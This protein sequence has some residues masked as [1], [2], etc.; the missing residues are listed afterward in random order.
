[1]NEITCTICYEDYP[2]SDFIRSSIECQHSFCNN[3]IFNYCKQQIIQANININ[4]PQKK[5]KIPINY[6]TIKYII[7]QDKTIDEKYE[8]FL[9]TETLKSNENV[10]WCPYE[11]CNKYYFI[12]PN[13]NN[14]MSISDKLNCP[15]CKCAICP[16]CYS[17]IHSG[18]SCDT[19]AKYKNKPKTLQTW[20]RQKGNSV[21]NCPNCDCYIEKN[22]GCKHLFCKA[23]NTHFCWICELAVHPNNL[24]EHF[25][26]SDRCSPP[27]KNIFN[28]IRKK[29]DSYVHKKIHI[30]NVTTY[31][32]VIM[33][34]TGLFYAIKYG[35][36]EEANA[37]LVF[38]P[39]IFY[40]MSIIAS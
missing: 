9:L 33:Y 38:P 31:V 13:Q 6:E 37:A 15:Y 12:S 36:K 16:V 7:R 20:V 40:T 35:T 34:C 8:G 25:M 18:I 14:R 4:C 17:D 23:C 21:K 27:R 39:L 11:T 28:T 3:C 19:H 1:M 32:P 2:V 5:C 30:P 26:R 22:E 10:R 29:I 24:N